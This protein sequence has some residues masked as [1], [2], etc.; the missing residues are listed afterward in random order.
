LRFKATYTAVAIAEGFRDRGRDVLFIMDSVTRFAA[1]LREIGLAAG[2][3][4]TLRGYPPSLFA[5]LPRVVER[6]G[7]SAKGS[8]TGILSVLVE[9]DD[10]NE[11][12][13]DTLR[14]L[15]DG[16]IVLD[17]AIA[18]RGHFPAIDVLRS[19]SRLMPHLVSAEHSERARELRALL[20]VYEESRELVQVGAWQRGADPMLDQAVASMPELERLLFHGTA[21]RTL[22]ATLESMTQI[23]SRLGR[24]A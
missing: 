15:L 6:L 21:P 4:P 20:A 9:G 22:D 23:A 17:R 14:G 11:P 16:H 12:V 8:I 19:V 10:M 5:E 24:R 18:A 2:E 3:P 13:S 1:S 7:A